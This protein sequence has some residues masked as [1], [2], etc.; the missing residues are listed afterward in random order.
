MVYTVFFA[1]WQVIASLIPKIGFPVFPSADEVQD[2][3]ERDAPEWP[4][5]KAAA[6]ASYDEHDVSL[7][8]S[9]SEEQKAWGGDR[10]YR[11]AAARRLRLID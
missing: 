11:V 2:M 3:R 10:L 1:F 6:I 4:E 8:F 5:I 7:T 9:A